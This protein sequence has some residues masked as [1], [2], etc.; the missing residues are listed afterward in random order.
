MVLAELKFL[1]A[2]ADAETQIER[3][4]R[5]TP[6]LTTSPFLKPETHRTTYAC[7]L[8]RRGERRRAAELLGE[9]FQQAQAAL[10]SGN[11]SLRV[12]MEI[13]TIHAVN[14]ESVQALDWL[15]RAMAA[16]YR[17]TSRSA[18]I[19]SSR[20]FDAIRVSRTS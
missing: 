4:F 7:L 11:E 2:T 10:A 14:R 20:V 19:R 13:A 12:P 15:E 18:A 8:M 5:N 17:I 9:S 1:T 16:G 3:L 6:G